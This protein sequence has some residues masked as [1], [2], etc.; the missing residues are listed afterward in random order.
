[1]MAD[2]AA[3]FHWSKAEIEA[4]GLS[5]LIGWRERAIKRWNM[6]QGQE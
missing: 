3:I 5:E 4:L 2:I 6:M 1:M